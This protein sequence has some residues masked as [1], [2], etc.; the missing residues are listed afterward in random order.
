MLCTVTLLVI[1]FLQFFQFKYSFS[2]N[3]RLIR[4]NASVLCT[5]TFNSFLYP[6][7]VLTNSVLWNIAESTVFFTVNILD[8]FIC[9]VAR[10]L[11]R[12]YHKK[13]DKRSNF[14][15]SLFYLFEAWESSWGSLQTTC[16]CHYK[17]HVESVVTHLKHKYTRIYIIFKNSIRTS[18]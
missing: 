6:L 12:K 15:K 7:S 13:G 14:L 2:R 1:F 9:K 3:V 8:G 11:N 4:L 10:F 5:D 17:W 16:N 18:E